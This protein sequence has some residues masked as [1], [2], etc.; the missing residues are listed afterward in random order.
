MKKI[1]YISLFIFLGILL[2]LVAHALIETLY[3]GLLSF[4]FKRWS[5]GLSWDNWYL[6]HHIA[7]IIFFVAGVAF[8]FWQGKYWYE[9]IYKGRKNINLE[10]IGFV[11][12]K[13]IENGGVSWENVNSKIILDNVFTEALDGIE[14]YSHILVLFYMD[15]AKHDNIK[16]KIKVPYAPDYV[17]KKG[18]FATRVPVRPNPIGVSIVELISRNKNILEVKGLD[19][20]NS[21]EVLDIK[22]FT[23]HR[24]DIISNFKIPKWEK[25]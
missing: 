3:I 10:P 23:G 18:I 5:F 17:E 24:R 19:A 22:P 15:K 4:N 21:T 20:L 11:E 8:G 25:K 13:I 16:L 2:Q 9:R 14:E 6:V 1:I 7:A 12:N